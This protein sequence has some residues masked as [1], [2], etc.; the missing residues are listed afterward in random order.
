ML[1]VETA[2]QTR[3]YSRFTSRFA[4]GLSTAEV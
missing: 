4:S 3:G 1:L 2:Q